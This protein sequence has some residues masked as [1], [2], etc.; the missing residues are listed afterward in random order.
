MDKWEKVVTFKRKLTDLKRGCTL[1]ELQECLEC[2]RATVYRIKDLTEM[3]FDIDIIK[4][5][6]TKKFRFYF[7]NIELPVLLWL[8]FKKFGLATIGHYHICNN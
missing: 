3:L 7:E 5:K 8:W 4:D 1:E 2:D 6:H